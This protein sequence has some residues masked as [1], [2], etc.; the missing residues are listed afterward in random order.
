MDEARVRDVPCSNSLKQPISIHSIHPLVLFL[1]SPNYL[2]HLFFLTLLTRALHLLQSPQVSHF[3]SCALENFAVNK[4][5]LFS[6]GL[7]VVLVSSTVAEAGCLSK[8][9]GGRSCGASSC[10]PVA[11]CCA[12]APVETCC[13]PAPEPCCA[14]A[15]VETCCAPAPEPCCAPAPVSSCCSVRS[16]CGSCGSSDCGGC[17]RV[18]PI[19]KMLSRLSLGGRNRC[20]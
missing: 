10:A 9:F 1:K 3:N 6:L 11:S 2:S 19:R 15:P 4:P 18:G 12:P 8:L 16:S 14:P 7:A 5:F 20:R 13:A 17:G